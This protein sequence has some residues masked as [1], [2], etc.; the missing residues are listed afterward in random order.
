[1][2]DVWRGVDRTGVFQ[3]QS[4]EKSLNKTKKTLKKTLKK[5]KNVEAAPTPTFFFIH[6]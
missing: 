4:R 6:K 2:T 1:M 3:H 5:T